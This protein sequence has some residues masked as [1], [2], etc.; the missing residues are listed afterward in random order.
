MSDQTFDVGPPK[1]KPRKDHVNSGRPNGVKRFT[2]AERADAVRTLSRMLKPYVQPI[3]VVRY[4]IK[5][6]GVSDRT[7]FQLVRDARTYLAMRWRGNKGLIQAE[8]VDFLATLTGDEEASVSEKIS[9]VAQICKMLGLNS[10]DK[11]LAANLGPDDIPEKDR[12]AILQDL[13]RRALESD[14]ACD[15]AARFYEAIGVPVAKP[16]LEERVAKNQAEAAALLAE[17]QARQAG[18]GGG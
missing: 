13:H 2:K 18:G 7:A 8:L 11:V 1:R 15:A 16:S 5:E 10:P 12:T 6:Y 9:A 4:A 17:L 3:S 14:E